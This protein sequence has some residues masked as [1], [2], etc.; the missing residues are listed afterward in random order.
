MGS[1]S[2]WVEELAFFTSSYHLARD[3]EPTSGP[4]CVCGRPSPV[5]EVKGLCVPEAGFAGVRAVLGDLS[6]P[7]SFW[8]QKEWGGWGRHC[9]HV[10]PLQTPDPQQESTPVP[11][12]CTPCSGPVG[13]GWNRALEMS[14]LC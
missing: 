2:P 5:R 11:S 13:G 6:Q 3:T 1:H 4:W 7:T 8:G 10:L 12:W 9:C 14:G